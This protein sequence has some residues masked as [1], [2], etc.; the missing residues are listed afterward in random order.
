MPLYQYNYVDASGKRK[1][2]IV[3]S[4]GMKEA[5]QHLRDQGVVVTRLVEKG[6]FSSKQNLKVQHTC[7]DTSFRSNLR[8]NRRTLE[9]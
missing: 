4:P 8:G 1:S 3:K 5:K 7:H 9:S 2:G 6:K